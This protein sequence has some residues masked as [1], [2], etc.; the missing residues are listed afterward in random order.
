MERSPR[1]RVLDG[2]H[3]NPQALERDAT[4]DEL[5][6]RPEERTYGTAGICVDGVLNAL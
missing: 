6:R 5:N 2:S 4:M 1:G 3:R